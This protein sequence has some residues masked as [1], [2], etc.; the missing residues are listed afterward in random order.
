MLPLPVYWLARQLAGE[1]AGFRAGGLAALEIGT[2][3]SEDVELLLRAAGLS[4]LGRDRDLAG[5]QRCVLAGAGTPAE[6]SLGEIGRGE[7]K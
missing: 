1:K 5:R 7:R 2:A 4:V 3:Q 6:R